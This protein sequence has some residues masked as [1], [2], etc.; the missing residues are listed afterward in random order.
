MHKPCNGSIDPIGKCGQK[1]ENGRGH[2][3]PIGPH[4]RFEHIDLED[5]KKPRGQAKGRNDI[6]D[7]IDF[8]HPFIIRQIWVFSRIKNL[9]TQRD[10]SINEI[11]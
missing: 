1:Q 3:R 10:H 2:E 4:T 8:P 9:F 7:D 11:F 5:D 6:G